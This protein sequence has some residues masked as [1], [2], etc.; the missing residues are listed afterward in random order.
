MIRLPK[1]FVSV[2]LPA[3]HPCAHNSFAVPESYPMV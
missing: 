3:M 1:E 2:L